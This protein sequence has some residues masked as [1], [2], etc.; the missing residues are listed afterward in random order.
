M[1][2]P[3]S[4]VPS[5]YNF[6]RHNGFLFKIDILP[7]VSYFCQQANIPTVS[8]GIAQQDTPFIDRFL[9]GEKL[10]YND[11]YLQF[12]IQENMINYIELYQWLTALGSPND[13]EQYAEWQTHRKNKYGEASVKTDQSDYSDAKLLILNSDNVPVMGVNFYDIFPYSLQSLNF[14]SS[15]NSTDYLIG[16]VTFKFLYYTFDTQL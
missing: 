6:L 2:I 7:N 3:N 10:T 5:D 9:P 15:S 16:T 14:T 8:L 11:L 1:A 4:N 12:I 13:Y